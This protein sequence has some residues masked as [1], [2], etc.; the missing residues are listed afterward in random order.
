VLIDPEEGTAA[1]IALDLNIAAAMDGYAPTVM[2]AEGFAELSGSDV[3]VITVDEDLIYA[4]AAEAR[5]RAPDAVIAVVTDPV[6]PMC[7]ATYDVALFPR[8]RVVGVAGNQH[9]A[10]FRIALASELRVSVRDVSAVVLGGHGTLVPV[11]SC[12]TVAGVP[13][14]RRISEERLDEIAEQV[15]SGGA[16]GVRGLSPWYA[17]SAAIVEVVDAVML[18]RHRVLPCAALCKGEYGFE[19]VFVGL[20]VKLGL[21]GIEEIV[22]MEIDDRERAELAESASAVEQALE[23][24]NSA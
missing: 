21:G 10:A 8:E 5:D 4:A 13:I 1:R 7:H 22:E 3:V 6:E 11:L 18:D 16:P 20:P 17:A 23:Q 9:S 2:G 14:R 15:R 12:A 19:E 24:P